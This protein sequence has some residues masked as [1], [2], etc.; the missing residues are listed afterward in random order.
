MKQIALSADRRLIEETQHRAETEDTTLNEKFQRW[1]SDSV[2]RTK[3]ADT[4]FATI[5]TL[6][7]QL[8]TDGRKSTR[9]EM[10]ER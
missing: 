6:R 8:S 4:A 3:Q 2:G 10:N 5:K 1:H 7:D 9:E